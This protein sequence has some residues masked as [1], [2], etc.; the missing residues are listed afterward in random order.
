MSANSLSK[1]ENDLETPLVYL[2]GGGPGDPGLITLRGADCLAI[3]DVILYDR[4]ANPVLLDLAPSET[5][6]IYVGKGPSKHTLP[7]EEINRLL[8]ERARAGQVV[9]R[10]HGGDPFVFG[11][12]GEEVEALAREGIPFE[13]VPGVTSAVAVPASV[14]IPVT[15]RDCASSFAVVTGHSRADANAPLPPLPRADT[16]IFLMIAN[17]LPIIVDRLIESGHSP[18]TP[19]ALIHRGTLPE[20]K[21]VVGDLANIIE[22]AE[23]ISPPATLV[24]GSVVALRRHFSAGN[25]PDNSTVP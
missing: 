16:L 12:G 8:V 20:Q 24:V 17:N 19:V 22:R 11:R 25:H 21:T 3:A 10:L 6:R 4:L 5:E 13:V 18:E 23:E 7:Q 1:R 9:V 14:G 2:V 15:H